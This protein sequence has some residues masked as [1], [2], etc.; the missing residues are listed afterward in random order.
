M[1]RA[2]LGGLDRARLIDRLAHHVHDAAQ[3]LVAD[4]HGD[5]LASVHDLLP[6][7]QTFGRVHGDGADRVLA[8]MLGDFE[9]EAIAL[10]VGLERVQDLRQVLGEL[11][12]D[13]RAHD[14]AHLTARA[15]ALGDPLLLL[16]R[17]CDHG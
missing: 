9:H 7:H 6:A 16:L 13:H 5:R 10:I 1:D 8:E 3:G 4:R 12:V 2:L 17:L 14:L 15:F 11:D